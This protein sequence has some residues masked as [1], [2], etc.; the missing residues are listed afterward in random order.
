M[1]RKNTNG[2]TLVELII[3]VSIISVLALIALTYFRGQIFKG[4]DAKRKSDINRIKVAVEEYEKDHNCYPPP[5]D[6]VCTNGG[7]GLKPYL[8]V[9]PCDPTT[10]ASY[11]Y[12]YQNSV[13]PSWY[14]IYTN[15]E[16]KNDPSATPGIGPN[17]AFNFEQSS[18]NAPTISFSESTPPPSGGGGG[19][20]ETGY[21]GCKNQVCVPLSWDS[22]RPGPEC[23][24]SFRSSSCYNVCSVPSNTCMPWR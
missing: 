16:N 9:I 8:D 7:T 13:C 24:P 11:L 22:A 18:S 3:V 6:V 19:S 14:R 5:Q 15:L 21:W 4:N 23:D 2:F 17:S 1:G 10:K 20:G 12:D